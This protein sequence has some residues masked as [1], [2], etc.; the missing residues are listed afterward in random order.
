MASPTVED[1]AEHIRE[2]EA[3]IHAAA[4]RL[5]GRYETLSVINDFFV[6]VWFLI[7]SVFFLYES[8]VILGTWLFI[9]G[10]AQLL[11][12]PTIRLART[13]HMNRLHRRA[14]RQRRAAGQPEKPRNGHA[15]SW[16]F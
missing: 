13:M 14:N 2:I 11:I 12:R 15:N 10:S 5:N 7:G 16:D 3:T 4:E 6:G 9:L 8:T 1:N